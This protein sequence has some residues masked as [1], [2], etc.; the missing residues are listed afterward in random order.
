MLTSQGKTEI[1][2]HRVAVGILNRLF[3]YIFINLIVRNLMISLLVIEQAVC[4]G[5]HSLQ[6][7][8]EGS[9]RPAF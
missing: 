9:L 7:S 5:E 3:G 8:P 1:T 2:A 4:L 6:K